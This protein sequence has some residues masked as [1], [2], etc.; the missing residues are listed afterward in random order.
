MEMF[1][2]Y[3]NRRLNIK[4]EQPEMRNVGLWNRITSLRMGQD[5]DKAHRKSREY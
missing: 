2:S 1:Y 4:E 5:I 3:Q